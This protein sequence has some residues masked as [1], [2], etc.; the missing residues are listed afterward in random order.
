MPLSWNAIKNRSLNSHTNGPMNCRR[1]E[2]TESFW[3][4]LHPCLQLAAFRYLDGN[5]F[6]EHLRTADF[7]RNMREF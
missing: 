3:T 4:R 6:A 1:T 2:K 5:L 7:N